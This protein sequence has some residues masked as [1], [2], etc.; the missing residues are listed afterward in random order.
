[1]KRPRCTNCKHTMKGHKKQKCSKI[2]TVTLAD[3]SV[4]TGSVYDDKPSGNG[5]IRVSKQHYY[6]GYFLNGQ[7]SGFGK[8]VGP[9]GTIYEGEWSK[10]KY[11]G[12]GLLQTPAFT[13]EGNFCM[14][15]YHKRGTL[16]KANKNSYEGE[17]SNGIKHGPGIF[18]NSD[19][20]YEGDFYYNLRHGRGIFTDKNGNEYRGAWRS[21]IRHGFGVY[22]TNE[23][24]YEGNWSSDKKQGHGKEVSKVCGT[25]VGHWKRGVKHKHGRQDYL[26]GQ[27]YK[28]GWS[29]GKKTGHGKMEYSDGTYYEGFWLNDNYNG[30]GVLNLEDVVFKGEWNGG[31]REGVFVETMDNYVLT[32][33]WLCDVRH[34][35]FEKSEGNKMTR[36]LYLWNCNPNFKNS[37]EAKKSIQKLMKKRDYLAAEEILNFYP[38]LI[39]WS[40]FYKYDKKGTLLHMLSADIFKLFVKHAYNLFQQKRYVFLE[41]LYSLC[42]ESDHSGLLFDSVTN[43]FTANPWIV[44]DQGYSKTTKQKLLE[45]LH[46]GEFGRC[47]PKNPFTRQRLTEDSGTWLSTMPKKAKRVY[48]DLINSISKM[49]DVKELAFHFDLQ[50]FET[51]LKNARESKDRNTITRLMKERNT[52]IQRHRL[53]SRDFEC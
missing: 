17:W 40:L 11:H 8:Q 33:P 39:K 46:L 47:P 23:Y 22:K 43:E 10:D 20:Q 31:E 2:E 6:V 13:Y 36:E 37:K 51:S 29:Y 41:R 14:G 49:S 18:K 27:C 25:Y 42:P 50:D 38:K 26:D 12:A 48:E 19:G 5:Y 24:T 4:Y 44:M 34:G 21:D 53:E 15:K 30:R 7:K 16:I 28:G 32:G 45:G 52:F 1:M 9:Y 35:T 3:G